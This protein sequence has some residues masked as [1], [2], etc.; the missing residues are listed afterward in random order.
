MR[1]KIIAYV[2]ADTQEKIDALAKELN[3]YPFN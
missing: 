3:M 2:L 1:E